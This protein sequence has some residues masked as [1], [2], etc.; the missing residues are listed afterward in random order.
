MRRRNARGLYLF[1]DQDVAAMVARV[2]I[3]IGLEVQIG[4]LHSPEP[5]RDEKPV[6]NRKQ[7]APADPGVRNGS[8]TAARRERDHLDAESRGRWET[9]LAEGRR[10]SL[11]ELAKKVRL[12][13]VQVEVLYGLLGAEQERMLELLRRIRQHDLPMADARAQVEV[14]RR[15]TDQQVDA[16]LDDDQFSSYAEMRPVYWVGGPAPGQR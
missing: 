10:A 8:R 9:S 4:H 3:I 15:A 14:I 6:A 11:E 12:T 5:P 1:Q 2:A 13:S 7:A 16:E